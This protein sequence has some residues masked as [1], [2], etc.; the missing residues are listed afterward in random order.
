MSF[1]QGQA[2]QMQHLMKRSISTSILFFLILASP[3]WSQLGPVATGGEATGSGGTVSFSVGQI[4]YINV[5][6]SAGT[7]SQG[8]QQPFEIYI[9][10]GNAEDLSGY[11]MVV[12]P[13]PTAARL[14]L[15]I[16][17][18]EVADLT[19]SLTDIH[20][21]SLLQEVITDPKTMISMEHLAVATYFLSVMRNEKTVKSFKIIK[22]L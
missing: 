12:Y 4:D 18:R 15:E 19:Y 1:G 5:A 8:L 13:N 11:S 2:P 16:T 9:I 3:L 7:V 20:G 14:I 17:G 6:V 21:H 10:T 22:T